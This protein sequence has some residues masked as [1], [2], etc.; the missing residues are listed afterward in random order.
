MSD[1]KTKN[2]RVECVVL[3]IGR[4]YETAFA[5]LDLT[6]P[7]LDPVETCDQGWVFLL[8]AEEGADALPTQ[9]TNI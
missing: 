9:Q 7:Y 8:R 4:R 3:H 2:A 1:V 6:R 5:C